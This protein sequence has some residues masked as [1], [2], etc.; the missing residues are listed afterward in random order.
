[1]WQYLRTLECWAKRS[2]KETKVHYKV[3]LKRYHGC[4]ILN[5]DYTGNNWSHRNSNR[6]FKE[7]FG[8]HTRGTCNRFTTKAA[9]HGIHRSRHAAIWNLKPQWF[10]KSTR[11]TF[12]HKLPDS[13]SHFCC[14][15]ARRLARISRK[16]YRGI[17]SYSDSRRYKLMRSHS[18]RLCLN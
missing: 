8:S 10:K 4:G 11:V 5:Y 6:R 7:K 15:Y 9:T 3:H 12:H 14:M 16:E 2:R 17:W 13:R 18:S 1:M